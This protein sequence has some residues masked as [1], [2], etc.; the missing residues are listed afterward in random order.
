MKT[1]LWNLLR[2][3]SVHMVSV[4]VMLLC[5]SVHAQTVA[6]TATYIGQGNNSTMCNTTF[7]ISGQSPTTNTHPVFTWT[8]GTG[9]SFTDTLSMVIVSAMAERGFVA[10]SV[11][12]D[13]DA[14]GGN[15]RTAAG[16][17]R[18]IYNGSSMTS[19]VARLCAR[20]TADCS[21]GIVVA[22]F[23]QGSVL[24]ELAAN[25][26]TRVRA[27]WG[28]GA[29]VQYAFI[30]LRSALADGNRTLPSNRLRIVNGEQDQFL[31]GTDMTRTQN[32]ELTGLSCGSAQSCLQGNGSGWYV[33]FNLQVQD[34]AADHCYMAVGG[35]GSIN[36][37]DPTF[38]TGTAPWSMGP[39]MDFLQSFTQP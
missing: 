23:S 18:C 28:L 9:E 22:G 1:Q 10:A 33:V 8:V 5:T 27:A 31:A 6:F 13:N 36:S 14:F 26:D 16:K 29:G 12:Y 32:Q 21:K 7:N 2:P 35:C 15:A 17:A 3:A 37:L 11:Q 25:F 34:R 30:N 20:P 19:A 4:F 39:N 24:A 38:V